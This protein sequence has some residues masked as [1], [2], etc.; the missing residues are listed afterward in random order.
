VQTASD[1]SFAIPVLPR[2]GYLILR[3]PTDDYV[4]QELDRGL[5]F[6]GQAGSWRVY[7]HAFRACNPKPGGE[8]QNAQNV[9][10]ALRPGVTVKGRVV[11]PDGQPIPNAWM[12]SRIHRS[13]RFPVYARWSGDQHG[14]ARDGRF[15]LHGLDPDAEVPVSFL[16]PKRKRGATVR[17]SG[18]PAGGEPIVVKLE[19][20]AAARARLVGPDGKPLAGFA[21]RELI[22]MIVTPGEFSTIKSRK[23]GTL[24]ADEG[25]VTIIDTI[26]Y[27]NDPVSDA[28]GRIV[29]PVLIPGATYRIIDH[30]TIR[31]PNGR[32]LR[33]ELTVKP[34]ELLDLG[35][36]LIEKPK[37]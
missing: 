24:L 25:S 6:N 37:T 19:Q 27:Q 13:P 14:T 32:Q 23:D 33:K 8:S 36:I 3:G 15:E 21:P 16:E 10:V 2:S 12:L 22:S 11:G 30:S 35:D 29:F 4:L 20:C 1:G 34:G 18:R 7:A 26:N 5:L 28:Q 17:F 31:T 9:N